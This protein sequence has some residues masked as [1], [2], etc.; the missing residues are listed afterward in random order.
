M[1]QATNDE[2]S[3]LTLEDSAWYTQDDVVNK[4]DGDEYGMVIQSWSSSWSIFWVRTG[5]KPVHT[6]KTGPTP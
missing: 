4:P 3:S 5:N 6:Q 1:A 2:H